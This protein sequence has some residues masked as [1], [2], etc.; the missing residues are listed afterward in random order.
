M[1]SE[2]GG[3]KMGRGG[4]GR[5][6]YSKEHLQRGSSAELPIW[7]GDS[8][9]YIYNLSLIQLYSTDSMAEW[10]LGLGLSIGNKHKDT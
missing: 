10:T 2:P 1:R 6:S 8:I 7:A 5:L 9:L 3:L 4:L